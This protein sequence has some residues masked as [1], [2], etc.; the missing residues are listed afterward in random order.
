LDFA[1]Q[2]GLFNQKI[3]S[4]LFGTIHQ[5]QEKVQQIGMIFVVKC[6]HDTIIRQ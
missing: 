4:S 2:T 3:L 6:K 5:V 1:E